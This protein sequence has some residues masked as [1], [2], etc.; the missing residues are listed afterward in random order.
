MARGRF[1]FD[2]DNYQ[3]MVGLLARN[4]D[5]QRGRRTYR[6]FKYG[7]PLV[8][9]VH[10]ACFALDP[11]V[12]AKLR[13]TEVRRPVFSIGH[14]RSGTTYQHR[15][16]T[17]D[18]QFSYLLMWEMFFPSL[19]EKRALRLLLAADTR[20]GGRFQRKVK[21]ME[22]QALAET[23]DM[24][25]T[26]LFAAEEDEFLLTSSLASG[27][28]MVLFPY[29]GTLDF[30][31]ID[32][33]PQEKRR[34]AMEFYR[35]CVRRQLAL[36]D[37]PL[38]LSKNANFAGRMETLIQTFPDA[39]I[40][41]PIRNPQQTIPS[42]LK[43]MQTAWRQQGHDEELIQGSLR[44][45][46]EQSYETYR[47]PFEVL[48]AHPEVRA[49]VLDYRDLVA[50]PGAAMRK[51]YDDLDLDL[52]PEA[53]ATFDA[54]GKR[55]AHETSHRYSLE[56]FGLESGEIHDRLADL[57]DHYRWDTEGADA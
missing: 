48:A 45:L 23:N 18:P 50:D 33:W 47:H 52:T 9:G 2:W 1:Y 41:I 8:A 17:A 35:E 36:N 3:T 26:G 55:G 13:R 24:H 14:A 49:T 54:A 15:L 10:A 34:R 57:F 20:L 22:E 7:V 39:R 44:V 43:M 16:M 51:V 4:R 31:A 38:H 21:E 19:I 5:S 40:I 53:V 28:W 30:H 6:A 56:E 12:S 11:V 46:A 37:K 25:Q 32:R 42:L 29:V 27:F